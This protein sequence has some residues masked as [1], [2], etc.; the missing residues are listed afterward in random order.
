[1]QWFDV[2]RHET[3]EHKEWVYAWLPEGYGAQEQYVRYKDG[4]WESQ[5]GDIFASVNDAECEPKVIRFWFRVTPPEVPEE[6]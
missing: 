6:T 5:Y 3:P 1:M 4:L 2:L